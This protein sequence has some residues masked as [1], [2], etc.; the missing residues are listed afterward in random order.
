MILFIGIFYLTTIRQG[1][2]WGDDFSMYI[3][4]AIN[5]CEGKPYQET[6]YIYIP[7]R[8]SPKSYPPIFPLLL[9]PIYKVFGLNLT[10]MKVELII[11][12]LI[13]L[14]IIFLNFYQYLGYYYSAIMLL[15]ISFSP[16][17]WDFKDNIL[18]DLPFLLFTYLILYKTNKLYS[19]KSRF[20]SHLYYGIFLGILIYIA[21]GIRTIGIVFIPTIFIYDLI[22]NNKITVTTISAIISSLLFILLQNYLF[23]SQSYADQLSII[24]GKFL[25]MFFTNF[26]GYFFAFRDLWTPNYSFPALLFCIFFSI[27]AILG[28]L[29]RCRE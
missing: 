9:A 23:G 6:G 11:I 27:I 10:A 19:I 13:S 24:N 28:Y 5:I 26:I 12:F 20:P 15:I 16:Y 25:I 17:F 7:S 29:K 18:S 2:N 21:Y 1:H 22:K 4:H 3:K 14:L 8:L